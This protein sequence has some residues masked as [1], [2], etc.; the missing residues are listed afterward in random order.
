[1]AFSIDPDM[2]TMVQHV[3]TCLGDGKF[4][5]TMKKRNSHLARLHDPYWEKKVRG[6]YRWAKD[7]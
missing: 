7:R 4:I 3:G 1:M 2:P 5:H 6:F